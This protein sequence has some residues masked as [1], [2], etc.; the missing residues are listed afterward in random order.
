MS[1]QT[2]SYDE[3]S[4]MG[5]LN[6]LV[7]QVSNLFRKEFALFRAETGEKLNQVFTAVGMIVAGVVMALVALVVLATALVAALAELGL[8]PGWAALIVGGGIAII[9]VFLAIKG[10][11][12]L[13]ASQ[14]APQRTVHSLEKDAEIVKGARP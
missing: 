7:N 1:Q 8:A 3:R 4:T 12:D 2:R 9:A 5:L 14:L 11:N 13:R 10:V 6:D